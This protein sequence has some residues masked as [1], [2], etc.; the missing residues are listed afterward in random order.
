MS[1][2]KNVTKNIIVNL[3]TFFLVTILIFIQRRY[4]LH[5]LGDSIAG[6]NAV[7]S[8]IIGFLSIADLGI[9]LAIIFALYEPIANNDKCRIKGLMDLYGKLYRYI[10]IIIF[11]LGI[12]ISFFLKFLIKDFESVGTATFYYYLFLINTILSYLFSYKSSMLYASQKLYIISILES[13]VKVVKLLVQIALILIYKSYVLVLL[14]EIIFNSIYYLWLNIYVNKLFPWLK[15]T[16]GIVDDGVKETIIIKIKALFY[17]KIGSFVVFNTDSIA[18]S[19]FTNL[20]FVS[21]YSNY[22]LI[23][24]FLSQ[25]IAK[26]FDSTTASLGN[27]LISDDEGKK[28][29]VF[30]KMYLVNFW[31]ATYFTCGFYNM[32]NQFISM[33]IGDRY[34]IEPAVLLVIIINFYITSMRVS[35]SKFQDASGLYEK[36]KY[37]PICEAGL[38]LMFTII[39]ANKYGM[40]GVFLGTLI[41]NIAVILWV[42]PYI[43]YKYIFKCDISK[44]FSKYIWYFTNMIIILVVSNYVTLKMNL[45]N[46][47]GGFILSGIINTFLINILVILL[48]FKDIK[49]IVYKIKNKEL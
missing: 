13:I 44:Y 17:H 28:Y 32:S 21:V 27:L 20:F 29:S 49:L 46:T 15:E 36:D 14:T 3:S 23:I 48:N 37:A 47:I 24:S 7:F 6:I 39:L 1:R 31:I 41:S 43:V 30:E 22:N 25:L 4:F 5:I 34:I 9:G 16:E 8:N 26:V 40:I 18:I 35:I 45:S 11:V 33:W 12:V 42:K 19:Y 10:A 2:K 38:N